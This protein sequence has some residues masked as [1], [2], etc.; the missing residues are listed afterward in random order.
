MFK[1]A[2]DEKDPFKAAVIS[3]GMDDYVKNQYIAERNVAEFD[4]AS[5]RAPDFG[6]VTK[7]VDAVPMQVACK[8]EVVEEDDVK[9]AY[10]YADFKDSLEFAHAATVGAT[11][12][13]SPESVPPKRRKAAPSTAS[14]SSPSSTST[15]SNGY[16]Y[17]VREHTPHGWVFLGATMASIEISLFPN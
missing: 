17:G 11:P 13:T 9:A 16:A 12:S 14:S 1:H 6:V 15:P 2:N 8:V 3:D 10:F 4:E 5:S 7:C